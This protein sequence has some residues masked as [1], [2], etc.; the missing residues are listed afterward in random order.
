MLTLDE[1]HNYQWNGAPVPGVTRI[2][3]GA[4]GNPFAGVPAF[5]LERKRQ[6]GVAA[7]RAWDLDDQGMLNEATV[8]PEVRPYLEAWRAFRRE[9]RPC[10]VLLSEVQMYE[11]T[12]GFAGTPDRIV[13]LTEGLGIIDGKTG[14]PGLMASLQTAGY[15]ALVRSHLSLRSETV[16]RRFSLQAMKNE[17][18]MFREYKSPGDWPDFLAC[19]RCA[20]LRQRLNG[21]TD[22]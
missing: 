11:P 15:E 4:L 3:S 7:H 17:R 1:A 13:A 12:H 19:L 21:E 9:F 14:L 2:I 18:Y 16:V 20:R 5:V 22:G 8:H 10:H 6:I